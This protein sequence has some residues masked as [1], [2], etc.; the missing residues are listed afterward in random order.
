VSSSKGE[1]EWYFGRARADVMDTWNG[2]TM[3]ER[4]SLHAK[5]ADSQAPLTLEL[6][7]STRNRAHERSAHH[8]YAGPS[9]TDRE[10]AV[11]WSDWF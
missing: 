8:G 10:G 6:S 2:S 9:Q 3:G 5:P 4:A 1:E 7:S 11:C